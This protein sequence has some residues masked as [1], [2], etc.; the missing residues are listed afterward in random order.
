MAGRQIVW[1]NAAVLAGTA[2]MFVAYLGLSAS[3]VQ[4]GFALRE[5]SATLASLEERRAKLELKL[6]M[7]RSMTNLEQQIAELGFEKVEEVEYLTPTG[8]VA[9]RR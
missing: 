6:V 5:A 8:A 7:Q 9:V 2:L 1:L 3:S 4:Q